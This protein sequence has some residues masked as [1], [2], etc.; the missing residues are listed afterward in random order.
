MI[1][2]KFFFYLYKDEDNILEFE[3]PPAIP[4]VT[5]DGKKANKNYNNKT[6]TTTPNKKQQ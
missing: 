4:P 3:L 2:A 1:E 6:K 5:F